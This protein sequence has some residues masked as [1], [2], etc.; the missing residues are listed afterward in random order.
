LEKGLVRV[1]EPIDCKG[2][3]AWVGGR[4]IRD[5]HAMGVVPFH[6]AFSESSN[7]AFASLA[8]Q[9]LESNAYYQGLR[10]FGLGAPTGVD[11]P[12][13]RTGELRSVEG[14]PAHGKQ[15]WT[16]MSKASLAIGYETSMTPMQVICALGAIGNNG[17]RMR[18]RVVKRILDA[19]GQVI[20]EFKPEPLCRVVSP[21]TCRTLL[22]LMESVVLEG[23][24][25]DKGTVPGY[26][27]GGK[28]GTTVKHH[29]DAAGKTRYV[30]SFA[31]LA[32]ID[33]PRLAIYVYVDEPRGAKYGGDVAAPIFREICEQ[34][35]PTLGIAPSDPK[36]WESARMADIDLAT[37]VSA[38]GRALAAA[39]AP[40]PVGDASRA[41]TPAKP[42]IAVAGASPR[43]ALPGMASALDSVSAS[44]SP[45]PAGLASDPVMPD[46]R[47]LTM[48]K[49]WE[50]LGRAGIQA[51]MLGSGVAVRQEPAA[52]DR[53]GGGQLAELIFAPMGEPSTPPL[54]V[55]SGPVKLQAR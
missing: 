32:P 13:E 52:G 6:Q 47:G 44:G 5:A 36:A 55:N 14:D 42:A 40:K 34:A 25:K 24:A 3:S 37:S 18:P 2:G 28:T 41:T 35:L 21:E 54:K 51:R 26:R 9:R 39:G 30:S 27:V 19:N 43:P 48:V 7:I 50:R 49:A 12:G 16:S 53:L 8:D 11:L 33:R 17:W 4:V 15:G 46:C 23:T 1:D 10:A 38:L 22:S 29:L 31:G 45:V 20:Q